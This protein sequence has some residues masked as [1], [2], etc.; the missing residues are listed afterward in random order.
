M[1]KSSLFWWKYSKCYL[2]IHFMKIRR[3][4]FSK[5]VYKINQ[6]VF[7]RC[8]PGVGTW[9]AS[10]IQTPF[11]RECIENPFASYQIN[12]IVAALVAILTPIS[13]REEFLESVSSY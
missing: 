13:K 7:F 2:V 12:H 5:I 10:Y 4:F 9:A 1:F 3:L 8:P 6:F 11:S